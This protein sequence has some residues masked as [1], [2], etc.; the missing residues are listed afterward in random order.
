MDIVD[1]FYFISEIYNDD[2]RDVTFELKK[3]GVKGRP[4]RITKNLANLFLD[5]YE[6]YIDIVYWTRRFNGDSK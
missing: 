5:K 6:L 2:L 3:H 4:S 1:K